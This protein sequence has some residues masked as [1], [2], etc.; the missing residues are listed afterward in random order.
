MR[1]DGRATAKVMTQMLEQKTERK[2]WLEK[3][4][5]EKIKL[6]ISF[7]SITVFIQ[8]IGGIRR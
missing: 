3:E 8:V 1:N 5:E 6:R 7:Y 4:D 2:K